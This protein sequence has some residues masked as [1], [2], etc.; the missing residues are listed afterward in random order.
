[1]KKRNPLTGGIADLL[2]KPGIT[3]IL[4]RLY[5]SDP[6]TEVPE[7]SKPLRVNHWHRLFVAAKYSENESIRAFSDW[8][9]VQIAD[10]HAFRETRKGAVCFD[11]AFLKKHEVKPPK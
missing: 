4:D 1:M 5:P 10:K 9:V 7:R 8:L 3:G 11:L 2:P 6:D